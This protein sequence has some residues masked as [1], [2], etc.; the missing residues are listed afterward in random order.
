MLSTL[1]NIIA[2][3]RLAFTEL[4]D[5]PTIVLPLVL[6]LVVVSAATFTYFQ[7]TDPDLLIDDLLSQAGN[8]MSESERSEARARMEGM[9]EGMLKWI[10]TASGSIGIF[11]F[12]LVHA[13]YFYLSSMFNGTKIGYKPW[14]SFTTWSNI[15]ML[16]SSIAGLATL[17]LSSGHVTM[18]EMNPF[19][20][21]NL[22][23]IDPSNQAL[24]ST[25]NSLD[26]TRLWSIGL[27]LLG[28]RLWTQKSWLH[29]GLVALL[30][31]IIVYGSMYAMAL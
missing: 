12:L 20:L 5:K 25:L 8:D 23:N 17:L 3:P 22:L 1:I 6:L 9:P 28:Y 24:A 19:T 31:L 14:L 18:L 21:T 16:F 29:C 27:M 15:P 30:P 10:S 7:V 2:A 26:L 11:L 13:G 4:R